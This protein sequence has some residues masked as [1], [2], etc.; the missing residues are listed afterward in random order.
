MKVINRRLFVILVFI[1]LPNLEA[2]AKDVGFTLGVSNIYT[3]ISDKN[4]S[5]IDEYEQVG[6]VDNISLG[7]SGIV[8]NFSYTLS[9]TRLLADSSKRKVVNKSGNIFSLE[10]K[11]TIDSLSV[12]YTIKRFN[13]SLFIARAE[14]KKKLSYN[15]IVVGKDHDVTTLYGVS[16]GYFLT[17]NINI[18]AILVA[19]NETLGLEYG[20]GLYVNLIL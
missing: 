17:R 18:G 14:V 2:F 8:N 4:Y 16:G 15:N 1:L 10:S 12:G 19:P 7:I 5:Y 11:T 9:S 13:P 6:N 20:F 3:K